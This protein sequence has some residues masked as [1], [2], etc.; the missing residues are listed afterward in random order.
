MTSALTPHLVATVAIVCLGALQFGYHMAELNSPEAVLSCRV[1]RPGPTPYLQSWFGRHGFARCIPMLPQEVGTVT[2]VFLLGGLL[3][4]FFV[5]GVAE[6]HGRRRTALW[7]CVVFAA[8]L[9]LNGFANLYAALVAGRFVAGVGAGAALATGPVFI[10]EVAP[11]ALKGLLGSM[12]QVSVNLGILLTQCLALAWCDD[13]HW[14]L[15]LLAGAAVAALNFGLVWAFVDE[16]PMWLANH[17]L[18]GRAYRGLH[19]LRGGDYAA[20]RREVDLWGA[21]AGGEAGEAGDGGDGDDTVGAAR[22]AVLLRQYLQRPEYANSRLV[23]TGILIA[24][25][26]CGINSIIFYG[27][28]VLLSVFPDYAVG[29]NCLI[30]GVNVVV[31]FGSAPLI[32]HWGRKPLLMGSVAVM[33]VAAALMGVGIIYSSAALC[34]V[35]TFLYI[36]AFAMGLG[37]IP[38]LLVAEITQPNVKAVAQSWGTACN[39]FATGVVGLVF[40]VLKNSWLG[41]GVYFI[42]TGFCV[43]TFVFVKRVVPETKGTSTYEEVWR[44]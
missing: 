15:L 33:S 32:D 3:G 13:N 37:P 40:P 5:G 14:R 1:P 20:V 23:S 44:R 36:I 22:G 39:W 21:G 19:R 30:L 25:Q 28:L 34:I 18:A 41:G 26:F 31:T 38:F 16:S 42:F 2:L 35:G 17:G 8:G 29:I 6:R 11:L 4:S 12:N 43:A 27:V 9:L 10:N 7:H 24:Q